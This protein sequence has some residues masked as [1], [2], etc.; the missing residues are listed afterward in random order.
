MVA[1]SQPGGGG[2]GEGISSGVG[3]L[4]PFWFSDILPIESPEIG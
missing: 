1:V 4:V 2:R 3:T